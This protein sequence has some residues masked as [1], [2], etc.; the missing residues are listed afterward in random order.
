[1]AEKQFSTDENYNAESRAIEQKI[2]ISF[3]GMDPVSLYRSD[4]LVST[5][6]LE[7]AHSQS[8]TTPFGGITSNE[9]DVELLNENGIFTPSNQ[10]SPYYGKMK[11]GVKLEPFIRPMEDEN[12]EYEWDP[13]GVYYVTDWSATVTG[14]LA[15]VTAND[16]LY[17]TFTDNVPDYK[18]H[19]NLPVKD[20]YQDIFD[21]IGVEGTIDTTLNKIIKYAYINSAPK[22]LFSELGLAFMADCFCKHDGSIHVRNLQNNTNIRATITDSNQIIDA[23]IT[24][25]IAQSY[26]GVSITCNH[27]QESSIQ[28]IK[29]YTKLNIAKGLT[30]AEKIQFSASNPVFR[31]MYAKIT[32]AP[33]SVVKIDNL[34]PTNI[35]YSIDNPEAEASECELKFYGTYLETNKEDLSTTGDNL[36]KVDNLYLQNKEDTISLRQHILAYLF[37]WLPLLKLT[38]RGNPKLELGDTIQAISER[39]NLN[40][41]GVL[42]KQTFDYSSSGLTGTMLLLN[43]DILKEVK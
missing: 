13:L 6:I 17:D 14:L 4:Y 24:Q 33:K 25:S 10:N 42:I 37:N 3:E 21:L 22:A 40:Y 11:R 2:V 20:F 36:V 34:Y 16:K 23:E 8:T 1:M 43:T 26:D 18:I 7:E 5:S 27:L 39:Y 15:T 32:G 9:I 19:M 31:L 29:S 41:T 35:S 30:K 38:V 28:E 12:G